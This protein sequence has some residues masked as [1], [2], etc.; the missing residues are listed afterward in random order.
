MPFIKHL[1]MKYLE[2][3]AN[4]K[5]DNTEAKLHNIRHQG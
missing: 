2:L 5:I 4:W 3:L 1:Y